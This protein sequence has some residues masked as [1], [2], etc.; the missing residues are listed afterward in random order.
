MSKYTL[1]V[2]LSPAGVKQL[3]DNFSVIQNKLPELN[4]EFISESLDFLEERAK[5]HLQKSYT[6]S[7]Y[8]RTE[9]LMNSFKKDVAAQSLINDCWY[10]ALVEYGTGIRGKGTHPL[11][12]DYVYDMN[13]HG[14]DGWYFYDAEGNLRWTNGMQAHRF[15]LE[16]VNDYYFK[17]EYKRIFERVFNRLIG[18]EIK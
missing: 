2:K 16:A 7:W 3:V 13:E 18:G 4:Q 5:F 15:M 11:P 14:E 12:G 17:G 9:T 8:K 6:N 1:R 10:A